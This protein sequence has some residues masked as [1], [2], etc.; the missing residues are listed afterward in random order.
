MSSLYTVKNFF[1]TF[2]KHAAEVSN[3][4]SYISEFARINVSGRFLKYP[5]RL[6]F[7]KY[8]SYEC[9]IHYVNSSTVNT[10]DNFEPIKN[11]VV[12]FVHFVIHSYF[13]YFQ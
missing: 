9:T 3:K 5:Q 11:K 2:L 1:Q 6:N 10:A 7:R 13:E 8:F 4:L 12:H